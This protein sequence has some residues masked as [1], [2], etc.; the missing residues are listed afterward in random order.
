MTHLL[1]SLTRETDNLAAA[2]CAEGHLSLG[3]DVER[4]VPRR[5]QYRE[6]DQITARDQ[7]APE[8]ARHSGVPQFRRHPVQLC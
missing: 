8:I 2:D 1:R 3:V 4:F 5:S 7:G 6:E